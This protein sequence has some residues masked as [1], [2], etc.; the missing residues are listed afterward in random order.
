MVLMTEA[1]GGRSTYGEA[2]GILM[3]DRKFA[4][5]PGD[6][7]NATT[8]DFAVR[9]HVVK[10]LDLSARLKLHAGDE[11]FIKPFIE[12]AQDLEKTGVRAITTSCGFT[13]FYQDLISDAINIPFFSSSLLQIPLIHRLLRKD[14]KIGIVTADGSSIGLG[15]K[16]LEAAGAGNIPV[17][18]MGMEN[19]EGFKA[20]S[21]DRP[22][23]YP[24]ILKG[25]VV[26][27]ASELV[28]K[29]PDIGAILLECTNL[30][31][32]GKYVQ[33][34]LNLPVFDFVTLTNW[35]YSAVV[36]NKYNGY[37]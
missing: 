30:T 26:N 6:V 8:F 15:E 4:R 23:I 9:Y 28:S 1:R 5:I 7:G 10:G 17:A 20:I 25:D 13:I 32:Y 19:T 31:P 18:I 35:V 37:M 14:Q 16:H 22:V 12:A 33:N 27:V 29:N 36:K 11:S 3:Y 21:E 24:E 34:A 2:I